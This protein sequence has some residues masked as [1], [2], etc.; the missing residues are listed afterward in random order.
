MSETTLP[1]VAELNA[2]IQR[3]PYHQWLGL[4]LVEAEDGRIVVE[5][6]WREGLLVIV[7]GTNCLPR[8]AAPATQKGWYLRTA[9]FSP[10]SVPW[11]LR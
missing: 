5:V 2:K 1:D 4:E 3:A 9:T 10:T 6:P 7:R 8:Q 11:M